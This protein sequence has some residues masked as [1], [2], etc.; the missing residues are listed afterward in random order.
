[1]PNLKISELPSGNPAVSTDQIPIARS[2]ANYQITLG[3]MGSA[4]T[5]LAAWQSVQT[6]NFTAVAGNGYPVNTTSGQVTVTLPASPTV[7]NVIA[8]TDYAGTFGTNRLNINP[9]GNNINGSSDIY[10]A[11]TNRTGLQLVYVDSIQGWVCY[12]DTSG[13]L[14]VEQFTINGLV[15]AGGGG[16]GWAPSSISAAG[17]GAGGFRTYQAVYPSSPSPG[18]IET[19]TVT[20]GAGGSLNANGNNSVLNTITSAG[21]GKG[22]DTAYGIASPGGSGGGN[23]DYYYGPGAGNVPAVSPSQGNPGGVAPMPSTGGGGGAGSA[24]IGGS[25]G[26]G[27]ISTLLGAHSSSTSNTIGTGSKTFTIA[28]SAGYSAGEPIRIFYDSSNF[29]DGNITSYTSGTGVLVLNSIRTSGSGTYTSWVVTRCYA[30]GGG[31]GYLGVGGSGGGSSGA[32]N[33][34]QDT[35]AV[36][37]TGGGAAG[38]IWPNTSPYFPGPA[39]GNGGSGVVLISIPNTGSVTFSAGV[40]STMTTVGTKKVYKVTATSTTSETYTVTVP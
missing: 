1:M 13:S 39:I 6:I 4:V 37:N 28:T 16:S 15:V 18:T 24:G 22:A 20:V 35:S 12:G 32:S 11:T 8:F 33:Y 21:G 3:S 38:N 40:T 30:G 26:L 34:V 5:N 7:G 23:S 29:M 19:G 36:I 31:A 2:G 14:L 27:A 9:N 10:V 17:S 25:G